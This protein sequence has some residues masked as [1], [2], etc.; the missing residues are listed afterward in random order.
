MLKAARDRSHNLR[1]ERKTPDDG[2]DQDTWTKRLVTR[3]QIDSWSKM[4]SKF[5]LTK[6]AK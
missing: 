5:G 1:G 3:I 4:S 6:F 2:F